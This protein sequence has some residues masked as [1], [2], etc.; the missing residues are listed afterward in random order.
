M[1]VQRIT[2][3]MTGWE[4]GEEIGGGGGKGERGGGRDGKGRKKR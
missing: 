3:M 1:S 2:V 4:G